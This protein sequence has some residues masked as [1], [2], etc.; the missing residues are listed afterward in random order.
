MKRHILIPYQEDLISRYNIKSND[1][2][3]ILNERYVAWV[4]SHDDLI[5][6]VITYD[7]KYLDYVANYGADIGVLLTGGYDIGIFEARDNFELKLAKVCIDNN[8][9]LFGICKGMQIINVAQ[10]GTLKSCPNHWQKALP[11]IHTHSVE[12]VDSVFKEVLSE[13]VILVNSFHSNQLDVLGKDVEICGYA[14]GDFK[15]PEC[16]VVKNKPVVGVQ[17]H[18]SHMKDS[19]VSNSLLD[20]FAHI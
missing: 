20:I 9:P 7:D 2:P 19:F 15:V 14:G 18:P 13:D 5:S 8:I 3:V 10:G 12:L 6:S 11:H 4:N 17:W 1:K 16:I